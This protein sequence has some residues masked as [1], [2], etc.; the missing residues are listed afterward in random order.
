MDRSL[1]LEEIKQERRT[2]VSQAA[3]V[4]AIMQEL[5]SKF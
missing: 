2:L 4:F 5:F 1:K 3:Q